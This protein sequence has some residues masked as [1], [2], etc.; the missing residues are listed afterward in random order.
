MQAD[1]YLISSPWEYFGRGVAWSQFSVKHCLSS[2]VFIFIMLNN[3]FR[4]EPATFK[5]WF[6]FLTRSHFSK[7]NTK[8]RKVI[9]PVIVDHF[10][11][12][13]IPIHLLSKQTWSFLLSTKAINQ[14]NAASKHFLGTNFLKGAPKL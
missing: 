11:R 7:C 5:M 4:D 2:F 12:N 13:V 14:T 10:W 8:E 9:L 1:L 6:L 3:N